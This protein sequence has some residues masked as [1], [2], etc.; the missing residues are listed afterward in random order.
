[1]PNSNEDLWASDIGS[2]ALRTPLKI[3]REQALLLGPKTD[4]DV[5]AEVTSD[6]VGSSSLEHSF[7]LIVPAI[8]NYRYRLLSVVH[9][10]NS[11]PVLINAYVSNNQIRADNEED[12]R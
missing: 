3:L 4:H 12:F 8:N 5:M 2:G 7:Y 9:D 11:Y 6:T 10:V 1:M